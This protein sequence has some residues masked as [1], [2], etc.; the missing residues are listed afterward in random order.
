MYWNIKTI[1]LLL[2]RRCRRNLH[3]SIVMRM[4]HTVW[5][6]AME[7]VEVSII[8]LMVSKST[9]SSVMKRMTPWIRKSSHV[10]EGSFLAPIFIR[11][12]SQSNICMDSMS[13]SIHTHRYLRIRNVNWLW[14]VLWVVVRMKVHMMWVRHISTVTMGIRNMGMTSHRRIIVWIAWKV[15]HRMVRKMS[16]R[17][18]PTIH[19]HILIIM[20][21]HWK[22]RWHNWGRRKVCRIRVMVVALIIMKVFLLIHSLVLLTRILFLYLLFFCWW[23]RKS[24]VNYVILSYFLFTIIYCGCIYSLNLISLSFL[25]PVRTRSSLASSYFSWVCMRKWPRKLLH[26]LS[27]WIK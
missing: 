16:I 23:I 3:K 13:L 26:N 17:V 2:H 21:M 25:W 24:I 20:R 18:V 7:S 12:W 10:R 5:M 1:L 14:M 11:I 22:V 8:W 19:M 27:T 4:H 15:T 6:L 9:S